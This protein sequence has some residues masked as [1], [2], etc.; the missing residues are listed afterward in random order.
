MFKTQISLLAICISL[1]FASSLMGQESEI[2]DVLILQNGDRVTGTILEM[3]NS[4]YIKF[5]DN[6][7]GLITQ[8][9]TADVSKIMQMDGSD[10]FLNKG[11]K[12]V[13]KEQ[14]KLPY[15]F[16]EEGRFT[17]INFGFSFGE[18][19]QTFVQ[20]N[21]IVGTP[22]QNQQE[23]AIGFNVQVAVGQQFKRTFGAAL[24][25]SYDAYNLED[26]EALITPL[27]HFRGYLTAKN[28]APFWTFSTGYGFA[29]K[30]ESQG[31]SEA[32]GGLMFHPELGLRLGAA[33]KTNFTLSIGY[34]FQ[35]AE[36]V[37]EF[38]FNGDIQYRDVNYRRFLFSVG[39]LF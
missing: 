34:R 37:Q 36:Y 27:L 21:P 20:I 8:Y 4:E 14:K 19:E 7:T 23:T 9:K 16:K 1:F 26:G 39:L 3:K 18:R 33:E 11:N 25:L 28:V 38:P 22:I 31:I 24:G 5:K 12:P 30:N 6:E 29:L 15:E 17:A 32:K 13:K 35:N 10:S 2:Y